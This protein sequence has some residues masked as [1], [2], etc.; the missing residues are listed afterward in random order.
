MSILC[1]FQSHVQKNVKNSSV[2]DWERFQ[3]S[4]ISKHTAL[5]QLNILKKIKKSIIC[6]K[7]YCW[8]NLKSLWNEPPQWV[9]FAEVEW[10]YHIFLNIKTGELNLKILLLN[11]WHALSCLRVSRNIFSASRWIYIS[12]KSHH[13]C[14]KGSFLLNLSEGITFF[15]N[16]KTGEWD[17]KI[18]CLITEMILS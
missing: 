18:Y 11:Y 14:L 15:L 7:C 12:E 10:K 2:I 9:I 3:W 5:S 4:K 17:L 16:I 1:A 8:I 6:A 13:R